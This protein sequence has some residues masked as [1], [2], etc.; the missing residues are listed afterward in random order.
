[1]QKNNPRVLMFA[2][3]CY[4]PSGAEAIVT[5]KLV[6]AMI[7]AGWQVKVISQADFSQ[8]YP[9]YE[10]AN[11]KPLRFVIENITGLNTNSL[12]ARLF[13][14]K[15]TNKL[16]AIFWVI[17]A[18]KLGFVS[19]RKEQYEFLLSRATPQY[20]HLPALILKRIIKIPWVANWSDPLPPKKAPPPYG[21]G[22]HAKIPFLLQI[23]YH[24]VFKYADWHS[25]PCERLMK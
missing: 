15:A 13:G 21:E 4:P 19:H 1:M 6:L 9:T 20:G 25:F 18:I 2:P 24:A 17:K 10:H 12:F 5:S 22:L 14:K 23:Y 8:F 11:W 3:S 7:D 16:R